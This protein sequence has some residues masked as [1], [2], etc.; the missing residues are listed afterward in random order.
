MK[1][2]IPQWFFGLL[3]VVIV[4]GAVSWVNSASAQGVLHQGNPIATLQEQITDL[5]AQVEVLEAKVGGVDIAS[6]IIGTWTGIRIDA[7][8]TGTL[9]EEGNQTF[10]FNDDGTYSSDFGVGVAGEYRVVANDIV[11]ATVPPTGG[12]HVFEDVVFLDN[13]TFTS[14]LSSYIVQSGGSGYRHVIYILT[15]VP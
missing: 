10:T 1:K 4:V 5:Q 11:L 12:P 6:K 9:I 8:T 3:A 13:N 2:L 7:S 15:K 14:V